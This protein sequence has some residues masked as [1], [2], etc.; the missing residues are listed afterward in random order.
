MLIRC[1]KCGEVFPSDV[2]KCPKCNEPIPE[3]PH[4]VSE[5]EAKL[6]AEK[7]A[8]VKKTWKIGKVAGISLLVAVILFIVGMIVMNASGSMGSIHVGFI[9][10][11][12]GVVVFIVAIILFVYMTQIE[13]AYNAKLAAFKAK[14]NPDHVEYEQRIRD[15]LND[16]HGEHRTSPSGEFV[17]KCPTCGC[18][19][20]ERIS[21]ASRVA[22]TVAFGIFSPKNG[23][24]FKCK[25]CGY[26]W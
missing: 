14:S 19:D 12:S 24:Q 1:E 25:N 18:T 4:E 9:M 21:T 3:K 10:A 5:E 8:M 26:M 6:R 17:P 11:I 15:M 2:G 16:D 13:K 7:E 20:L 22:G 23:K